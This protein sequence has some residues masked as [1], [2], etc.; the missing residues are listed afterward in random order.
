VSREPKRYENRAA[1]K[2][3]QVAFK[4]VPL[5][6]KFWYVGVE[7]RRCVLA[8]HEVTRGLYNAVATN[9]SVVPPYIEMDEND[10]VTIVEVEEIPWNEW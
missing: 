10:I 3:K 7:Y 1:K 6:K 9:K 2:L 5:D 8:R 4:K